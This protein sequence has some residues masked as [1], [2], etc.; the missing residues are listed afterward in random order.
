MELKDIKGFGKVRLEKL[1]ELGIK[2][3]LDLLKINPKKYLDYSCISPVDKKDPNTQTIKVIIDGEFKST[4]F[5]GRSITTVK[6]ADATSLAGFTCV[7]YNQPFVKNNYS[8]EDCLYLSGSFNRAHQFVVQSANRV[9]KVSE[10]IIPMYNMSTELNSASLRSAIKQILASG[11]N[12]SSLSEKTENQYNLMNLN[13][14]YKLLHFPDSVENLEKANRRIFFEDM[15]TLAMLEKKIKENRAIKSRKY[16]TGELAEFIKMLPY[17]LTSDQTETLSTIMDDL[18]KP[19][20]MN[21]MVLGDVGSGKTV[22][23]LG[24]AYV[25]IKSGFQAV[26]LCPT[27]ILAK[28]HYKTAIEI[29]GNNIK[30]GLLCS[31]LKTKEKSDVIKALANNEID[32]LVSTH[33]SLS[34][35]VK[36]NNLGLVITDE[37]HRF[38]VAER[39]KLES[40]TSNPDVLVMSATPIPRSLAL[41]LYGG[42][43]FSDLKTRPNGELK[44]ETKLVPQKKEETMWQFIMAQINGGSS[45]CFVVVPRIGGEVEKLSGVEDVK[46]R[47]I[48]FGV[49]ENLIG[50]IHGKLNNELV[51]NT[52][53]DFKEDKIKVLISTT[54]IEVGID[55][56]SANLMVIYNADRFG[57]ATLHQ[58]RG[59]VGRDGSAGY[60]FCMEADE[61]SMVSADRLKIFKENKS[62]LA[63][64]EADLKLRGAGTMY[65]TRQ[66]GASEIYV[67][68][69]VSMED[70]SLAKK[71][72]QNATPD[73]LEKLANKANNEFEDIYKKVVMN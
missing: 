59:R 61:I 21:R 7:W 19:Y 35:N 71:I 11:E 41:V 50:I 53:K 42:L 12:F 48:G 25:V 58:L 43:D 62:G 18:N 44:I 32:L 28:Q 70:F 10:Q 52:I 30:V 1:Y 65:D 6:V 2:T 36:F 51:E 22:V 60:C 64:A 47:L 4:Y 66:H 49:P 5:K 38:G 57:L 20:S 40:K 23:A 8:Q 56:P 37:Q 46:K 15:L 54:I 27:E 33:S 13:Q 9:D 24:S 31:K 16:K 72:L 39:A 55:I 34:D 17:A 3:P 63:L 69:A 26:L 14:A 45:K 68:N 67:N 73:E 29:F